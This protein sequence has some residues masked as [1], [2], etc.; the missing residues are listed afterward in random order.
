[1][2]YRALFPL[3]ETEMVVS[4]L[5]GR[6]QESEVKEVKHLGGGCTHLYFAFVV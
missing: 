4:D 5:A 6:K 2:V 3:D 1:M